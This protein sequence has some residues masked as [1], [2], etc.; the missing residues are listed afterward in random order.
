M[1]SGTQITRPAKAS[2][3]GN[4][5]ASAAVLFYSTVQYSTVQYSTVQYSTVQY[6]T[7]QYSAV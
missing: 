7:V 4:N 6:S 5:E 1:K 3:G 2:V